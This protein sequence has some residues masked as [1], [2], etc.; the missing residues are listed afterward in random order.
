MLLIVRR[1]WVVGVLVV[2]IVEQ[3]VVVVL[4]VVMGEGGGGTALVILLATVAVSVVSSLGSHILL[5]LAHKADHH[6][7]QLGLILELSMA[8]AVLIFR[9]FVPQLFVFGHSFEAV[10]VFVR[11]VHQ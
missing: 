10:P 5:D 8:S 1:Y 6:L 2:R 7:S 3:T 9:H 4:A 11:R